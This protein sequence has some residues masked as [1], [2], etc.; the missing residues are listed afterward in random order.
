MKIIVFFIILVLPFYLWQ[1][2]SN[3][4]EDTQSMQTIKQTNEIEKVLISDTTLTNISQLLVNKHGNDIKYRLEKGL[5][6][7]AKLW[8]SSDGSQ[9]EFEKFCLEYFIPSEEERE[10]AFQKISRNIEELSGRMTRILLELQ[11]PLHLDVGQIHPIDRMFGGYDVSAHLEEDF[12]K[13]KIAFVIAL[14]FPFYSLEEKIE[15]GFSWSRKEWAYARMGDLFFSRVPSELIQHYSKVNMDTEIYISE[16]NI[17]MGSLLNNKGKKLFPKDLVLLTHWNLRDELKGN[18]NIP[19]GLEKQRMIYEVMKRIISQEIPE[20]VINSGDYD[21]NPYR[22]T[23]H[24][25][26]KKIDFTSEPDTRYQQLLNNFKALSA[27]DKYYPAALNTY[28]KRKFS[29][30]LEIPQPEVEKLF[31]KLISSPQVKQVAKLIAK[32]L[33]RKLEPFD[34]WY[35]GF[36]PRGIPEE[37]L[38]QITQKKYPTI[39]AFQ[40]DLPKLLIQLGFSKEKANFISTKIVVDPARGSG[41]AWGPEMKEEFAH[42]RTRV[43]KNGLDFKGYN[44]AI[45]EFGHNVEQTISLQDVDYYMM[46]GVPNTA[47]T[48]ALAF[49]FQKRD[50]ELLGVATKESQQK[51][52]QTLATF[53]NVYET[54]GVSL[55]DMYTWKWMYKNPDANSQQLKEAVIQIARDVWNKYYADILGGKDQTLLAI[56]SHM[57]AYP[58]YLSAYSYGYLIDF[59]I[60][61]FLRDKS[62]AKEIERMFAMGRLIPQLWMEKAVG[63][64]ISIVPI[65]K[66][67]ENAV[68]ALK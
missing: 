50:L 58:L 15:K 21:W 63:E 66:A 61:Q 17:F 56:Y 45:H 47:F 51:H 28:I 16:Y 36:K 55:V 48:E 27:Q 23:L 6:Q 39:Q 46:F 43:P 30:E 62:F 38:D 67:T 37:K 8:K 33:G 59:Q 40:D 65:L 68:N 22:N 32:R 26:S 42:L 57:I 41:H 20:K 1:V 2:E 9:A 7:L 54:M 52:M 34:I 5:S 64:K 11:E 31:I 53:W 29:G 12:F 44:I 10:L 25:D 60:E 13:N 24:K 14:N 35:S 3:N 4:S 19:N 49:I 18:Y